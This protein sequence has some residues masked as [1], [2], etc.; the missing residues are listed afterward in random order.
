[1]LETRFN[2]TRS[3]DALKEQE[4]NLLRLNEEDQAI[5]DDGDAAELDKEAAEERV[6]VRNEELGRF[7]TQ[8]AEREDAMPLRKKIKEIFKK[9]GVTVTAI[10]IAAG[11]TIGAVVSAVTKALKATEKPMAGSLKEIGA[12]PGSLLP[13]LIGCSGFRF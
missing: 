6:A 2:S 5:I 11:V 13:G 9:H 4:I 7:Q 8:I 10:L 1:L 12:K 3:F